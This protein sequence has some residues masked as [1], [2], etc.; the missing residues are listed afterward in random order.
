VLSTPIL[1]L[2]VS[3][4]DSLAYLDCSD[5]LLSSIDVSHN[6]SLQVLLVHGNYLTGLDV[7]HN[8]ALRELELQRQQAHR[9]GCIQQS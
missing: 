1:G 6:D 3:F 5:N 2:D 8:P 9:T 4:N 7:S